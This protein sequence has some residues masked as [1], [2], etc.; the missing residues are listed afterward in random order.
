MVS[1]VPTQRIYAISNK[2]VLGALAVD[3]LERIVIDASYIDQKKRGILEMK[4]TQV[5]LTQWLGRKELKDRY[6]AE[7]DKIELIFY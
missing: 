5:P 7:K 6:V 1:V 4:E 3:R 2:L